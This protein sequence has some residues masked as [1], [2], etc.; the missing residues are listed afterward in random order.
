MT[1]V[2]KALA[3]SAP[4]GG[5]IKVLLRSR[6]RVATGLTWET[7]PEGSYLEPTFT[8]S[9]EDAQR[10]MDDLWNCGLR[11]AQ[12]RQSEGV[13]AAQGRHLEDMRT[14]AFGKLNMAAPK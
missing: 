10:L 4:W 1:D 14:I 6:E 9:D 13:T 3:A 8:L 12:G 2:I 5:A 11:P 7:L